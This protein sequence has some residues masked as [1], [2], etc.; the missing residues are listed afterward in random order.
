MSSPFLRYDASNMWSKRIGSAGVAES[1]FERLLPRLEKAKNHLEQLRTS[2]KQGFFD[3]PFEKKMTQTIEQIARE[4]QKSFSYLIVIGIGGSDL[5]AR[6]LYQSLHT[7]KQ[8]QHHLCVDFVNN[9][10]P[11]SLG[12]LLDRSSDEWK[13]TA[14]H[15]VSKSG[16]TLETMANFLVLRERLIRAVGVKK[17]A[18][19]IFVTT[20]IGQGS[21]FE[22]ATEHGYFILP[23]PKHVGGRF[24]VLSSVGLFSAACAGIPI[25][26]ILNG[27][28]SIEKTYAKEGVEHDSACFAGLHYLAYAKKH[29]HIHVLMPYIDR[30]SMF[31]FWYRQ[32][33][34]ESLGKKYTIG[35]TPVAALGA[36]DQ[37]SQIQLYQDGPMDKV[38][39]FIRCE[40]NTRCISIPKT[41]RTHAHIGYL[42]GRELGDI[43]RA[44]QE[45]TAEALA[46]DGR[47]NGTLFIPSLS[48]ESLGALFQFYEHATVYLAELFGVN[49]FDQPGVEAGKKEIRKRLGEKK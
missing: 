2:G 13:K 16:S 40:K 22:L 3:L 31:T 37:H 36:I 29:Q 34:A 11:D 24:A 32:L 46:N 42:A 7:N 45:G 33:W 5:G 18:A 20:D 23:H 48:P 35:P 17:H 21:L 26:R 25:C 19:H 14:I 1:A 30:L 44:E 12:N 49:A 41:F 28:K 8:N 27:A 9:P 10:D 6:T 38:I 43:L 47:P 4:V 15:V 39:T